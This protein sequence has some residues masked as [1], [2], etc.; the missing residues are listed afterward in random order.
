[1][2]DVTR[3]HDE[4]AA[5]VYN[6]WCGR[7]FDDQVESAKASGEAF[8]I[9]AESANFPLGKDDAGASHGQ[10]QQPEPEPEAQTAQQLQEQLTTTVS[11]ATTTATTS[12]TVLLHPAE[13]EVRGENAS[14]SLYAEAP[15]GTLLRLLCGTPAGLVKKIAVTGTAL[16][17]RAPF[18][19]A[20]VLGGFFFFCGGTMDA[21]VQGGGQ[22]FPAQD[23]GGADSVRSAFAH[24]CGEGKPFLVVHPFGEQCFQVGWK[25][26]CHA[27][28]MFGGVVFGRATYGLQQRGRIFLSYSWGP[29]NET[30]KQVLP[31]KLF[32]ENNTRL[33]CWL[34]LE[35]LGPGCDLVH[36]MD[37]GVM[38][39]DV[40][41]CCLTDQY[42]SRPNCMR[43]LAFAKKYNKLIVPLLLDDYTSDEWPPKLSG[44]AFTEGVPDAFTD[45]MYVP[46]KSEKDITDNSARLVSV[47]DSE[48][49]RLAQ[50]TSMQADK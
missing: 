5:H 25:A 3:G 41:I 17:D 21:V 15:V 36:E 20:S 35:R 13:I 43:E 22:G 4:A 47:I 39:A 23:Q 48:V 37:Q 34:D 49:R 10:H 14:L 42:L 7:F 18:S 29:Q 27:N 19:R 8:N 46:W 38:R 32:L 6:R 40:F 26:P 33:K 44:S 24:A 28:L 30:Q 2:Q 12:P 1:M 16:D 9:L 31:L 45:V 11:V 50:V